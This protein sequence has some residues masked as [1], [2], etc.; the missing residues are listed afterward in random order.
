MLAVSALLGTA[1]ESLAAEIVFSRE[2]R[3]RHHILV[4]DPK[5][6]DVRRIASQLQASGPSWSPDRSHV[7]YWSSGTYDAG[8]EQV[9]VVSRTGRGERTITGHG[10]GPPSWSPDGKW[11]SSTCGDV[12]PCE[13]RGGL[14]LIDADRPRRKRRVR[15]TLRTEYAAWA[16]GGG[17][18]VVVDDTGGSGDLY[19][20]RLGRPGLRRLTTSDVDEA[21]PDWSPDGRW[22]VYAR[23]PRAP[24]QPY[25]LWMVSA[26]GDRRVRLTRTDANETNPV[27][28]PS[29]R[30][31][32]FRSDRGLFTIGRRGRNRHKIPGTTRR[33]CCPDW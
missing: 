12:G 18:I 33:E 5:G 29:G 14:Y 15:G 24:H 1:G 27:W 19:V 17:R 9:T 16:P 10:W 13:R 4:T 31:I 8:F 21:G 6:E 23:P 30:R 7:A 32:L 11:I 2:G 25:D 26:D 20:K 3:Q 28:S 22:I